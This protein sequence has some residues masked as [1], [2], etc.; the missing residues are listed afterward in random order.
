[1]LELTFVRLHDEVKFC[2]T[3][4]WLRPFVG[5]LD[6][7]LPRPIAEAQQ[8]TTAKA[9]PA[10]VA[11]LLGCKPVHPVIRADGVYLD[12][13]GHCVERAAIACPALR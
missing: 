8:R 11:E 9:A 1:M 4:V 2:S 7:V 5:K 12:T 10:N 6:S 3:V 13:E